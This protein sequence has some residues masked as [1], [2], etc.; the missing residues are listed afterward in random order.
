M[1]TDRNTTPKK[2]THQHPLPQEISRGQQQKNKAAHD[3]AMEDIDHDPDLTT[4]E[5]T[6]DLDEG[7]LARLDN[8]NDDMI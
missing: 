2:G 6:A 5:K 4:D 3:E 1:S 7:E 8:D